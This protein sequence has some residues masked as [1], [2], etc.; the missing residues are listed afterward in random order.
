MTVPSTEVTSRSPEQTMALAQE[1]LPRLPSPTAVLA[2][3][4]EL[5]TGKTCFV[6]GLARALGI[7]R[8]ITSPTFTIVNEYRGTRPLV[9]MD[10]YRL[11]GPDEVLALGFDEYL[12]DGG[13]IAIEWAERAADVLPPD[14]VQ[15]AFRART[16]SNERTITIAAFAP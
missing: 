10:L 16:G 12:L 5:G 3:V 9:H 2:L 4:G 11:H 15:V 1:L 7:E 13:V 8:P 6:R 14:T